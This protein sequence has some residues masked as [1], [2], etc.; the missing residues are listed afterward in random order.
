MYDTS[1]NN[2]YNISLLL[3]VCKVYCKISY[4]VHCKKHKF[5][6]IYEIF[7]FFKFK[8]FETAIHN[9]KIFER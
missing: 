3:N 5:G 4:S 2:T 1:R 6:Q 8:L 7:I 9:L